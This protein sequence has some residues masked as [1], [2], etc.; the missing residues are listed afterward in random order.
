MQRR[1]FLKTAAGAAVVQGLASLGL[2][3]YA[4]AGDKTTLRRPVV[5]GDP[6]TPPAH[7]KIRVA[8]AIAHGATVIDFAG[9]WEVF[10]DVH[11]D[12]RGSTMNEM[13]PF[14]LY[15]VAA[16]SEPIRATGGLH[17]IP[18]YTVD[19]A[20]T[21]HL[22]VVPALRGNAE[23]HDWLRHI[24]PETDVTMSVC[25]GAFQLAEAG[26]LNGLAATTHHDFYD[27]FA[28]K[29]PEV[30]LE[31]NVRFVENARISTA[32]GL[33]SGIDLALRVVARYFGDGVAEQTAFYMEY[34]G[35]D[36]RV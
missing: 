25:T 30:T 4:T 24:A 6:L 35:T 28:D 14:R 33:T 29:Y 26:L 11:V 5:D 36:W 22:V 17:I 20:P 27:S 10:Q 3:S 7:G 2:V 15:T 9:P 19:T 8:V 21:P 31:R 32:G 18:D 12:D 1:Q 23:L 16:T 34:S 13:M